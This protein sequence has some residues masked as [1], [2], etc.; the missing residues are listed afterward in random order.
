MDIPI[1]DR[2][3]RSGKGIVPGSGI[4]S[5]SLSG[6]PPRRTASGNALNAARG[7]T[8]ILLSEIDSEV[9]ALRQLLF[10]LE[11]PPFSNLQRAATWI[12]KEDARQPLA[13]KI[14]AE[15]T[16]ARAKASCASLGNLVGHS[17]SLDSHAPMLGFLTGATGRRS[18]RE[19]GLARVW[20]APRSPLARLKQFAVAV[21][22]GTG[23]DES[24]VVSY[25][26]VGPRQAPFLSPYTA[27]IDRVAAQLPG[28]TRLQRSVIRFELKVADVPW[29]ELRRI[30]RELFRILRVAQ[31]TRLLTDREQK[32]RNAIEAQGGIP[33]KQEARRAW[34]S[35][36]KHAEYPNAQAA[37]VAYGRIRRK[38]SLNPRTDR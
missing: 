4:S 36:A 11:D 28:G 7:Q 17:I 3:G 34:D 13:D 22:N 26:L 35:I 10:G 15:K 14:R 31:P 6:P 38:L 23:F 25:V 33:R 20:I 32:L 19:K 24:A 27:L 12:R 2:R 29:T 30:Y 5:P 37:R 21:A 16:Y 1:D 8:A 18:Q 9:R